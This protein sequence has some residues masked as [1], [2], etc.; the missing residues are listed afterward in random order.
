M[1][2]DVYSKLEGPGTHNIVLFVTI[3]MSSDK[4]RQ[5]QFALEWTCIISFKKSYFVCHVP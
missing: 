1:K 4:N 3:T 2:D 5:K